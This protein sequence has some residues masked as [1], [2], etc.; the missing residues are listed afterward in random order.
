MSRDVLLLRRTDANTIPPCRSREERAVLATG[1][2]GCV[3]EITKDGVG[4]V[5]VF[6]SIKEV[7]AD[8]RGYLVSLFKSI[9][10]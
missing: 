8:S 9:V 3:A 1:V 6:L 2:S 5:S 10:F 7:P 4:A